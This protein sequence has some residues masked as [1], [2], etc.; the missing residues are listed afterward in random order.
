MSW[1][2]ALVQDVNDSHANPYACAGCDNAKSSLC[3]CGLLTLDTNIIKKLSTAVQAPDAPHGIPY[4]LQVPDNLTVF[5]RRC[6]H[7]IVDM[8]ILTLVQV[9]N[10]SS[11]SLRL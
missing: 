5:L 3:L 9:P 1:F 11:N 6:R 10:N 8:R 4:V 2:V 7:P